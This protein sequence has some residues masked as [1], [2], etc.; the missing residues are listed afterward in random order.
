MTPE[1]IVRFLVLCALY[2]IM[3]GCLSKKQG[4]RR[5][6][7]AASMKIQRGSK[8]KED[9]GRKEA[10]AIESTAAEQGDGEEALV[11]RETMEKALNIYKTFHGT[12]VG[13]RF[14]AASALEEKY[15][16]ENGEYALVMFQISS[17]PSSSKAHANMTKNTEFLINKKFES[18]NDV[19]Q[20]SLSF[21]LKWHVSTGSCIDE[22]PAVKSDLVF[23]TI[24]S[25]YA[26]LYAVEKNTGTIRW[27]FKTEAEGNAAAPVV[28]GEHVL[29]VAG[30]KKPKSV[31]GQNEVGVYAVDARN[32][33][34]AWK[35]TSTIERT[36]MWPTSPAVANGVLYFA[37]EN[38][39]YA[40]DI[41]TGALRWERKSQGKFMYD[42]MPSTP[43]VKEGTAYYIDSL[44]PVDLPSG[45]ATLY[46]LNA[47][48]G[49][50]RWQKPLSNVIETEITVHSGIFF[51]GGWN[52]TLLASISND[53]KNVT[54]PTL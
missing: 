31:L 21:K 34:P 53:P 20:D 6:S 43:V 2:A 23:F 51:F 48:T 30:Q 18:M 13:N 37:I 8:S 28:H 22:Q 33:V 50:L 27:I 35:F 5:E 15:G 3:C 42:H 32:G 24:S 26:Y 17:D 1:T 14:W 52:K 47:D 38:R 36:Q 40:V 25:G 16:W 7:N 41:E 39:L 45:K 9:P 29:M 44:V 10:A 12:E 49:E 4:A 19:L 46:A 11:D 54:S